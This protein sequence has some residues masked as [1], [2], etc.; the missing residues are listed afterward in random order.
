MTVHPL[1]MTTW[2][3]RRMGVLVIVSTAAAWATITVSYH[4]HERR[5]LLGACRSDAQR[6]ATVVG[7][8]VHQRPKLWRYDAAKIAD[9]VADFAGADERVIA[10]RDARG[11]SVDLGASDTSSLRRAIWGRADVRVAGAVAARV[12][13]GRSTS[14]LWWR[15]L[16]VGA[17]SALVSLG[18]G[19][20]LYLLPVKAVSTAERRAA[21]LMQ[22]LAILGR[23]DERRRIARDLHDGAGQ[24]LTAA[25][26]HLAALENHSPESE[27]VR[28]IVALV[29]QAL[30]EIRKSTSALAPMALAELGL[31]SAIRRLCESSTPE[32]VPSITCNIDAPLPQ[33]PSNVETAIYR[34]VQEALTNIV[35]HANATHASVDLGVKGG[36]LRLRV[37]DDG[38]GFSEETAVCSGLGIVSIRTRA[39]AIGAD[40]RLRNAEPG[41][42]LEVVLPLP[43]GAT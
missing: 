15:T 34:I 13:V 8:S 17:L 3:R 41:T 35:K 39:E 40:V 31:A 23:D 18:L 4:V 30:D 33:V 2:F 5:D 20:L 38:D 6:I 7:D 25:R 32:S 11:A 26:L 12:W 29:D 28:P 42:I 14:M 24:A 21:A 43:E 27:H 1:R 10:V 36:V 16:L 37:T 22:Q 19:L 9:R